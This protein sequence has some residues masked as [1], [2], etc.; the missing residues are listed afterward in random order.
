MQMPQPQPDTPSKK[1]SKYQDYEGAPDNAVYFLFDVETTGSKRNWDRIIAMSFLACDEDGRL[2][3]SFNKKINPGSV[4]INSFLSKNIHGMHIHHTI[5]ILSHVSTQ[6][7][8]PSPR[9]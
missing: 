6:S 3:D 7:P 2:L 1:K 9:H 4:R 5:H 8:C